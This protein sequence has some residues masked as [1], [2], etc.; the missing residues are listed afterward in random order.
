MNPFQL[1]RKARGRTV[2]NCPRAGKLFGC[3]FGPRYDTGAPTI[4]YKPSMVD[5]STDIAR[6]LNASKVVTYVRDVCERCGKTIE[7]VS[8]NV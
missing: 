7:R 2:T 1:P 6:V 8:G 5:N 3:K 4:G